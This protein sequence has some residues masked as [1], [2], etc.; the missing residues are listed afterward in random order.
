[1]IVTKRVTRERRGERSKEP[2]TENGEGISKYE[3]GV[4]NSKKRRRR[5]D[6]RFAALPPPQCPSGEGRVFYVGRLCLTRFVSSWCF[7]PCR[8]RLYPRGPGSQVKRARRP[9]LFGRDAEGASFLWAPREL[10]LHALDLRIA[11]RP[12]WWWAEERGPRSVCVRCGCTVSPS[13][14]TPKWASAAGG[15]WGVLWGVNLLRQESGS[16][17]AGS[18]M[19][20][21]YDAAAGAST[22]NHLAV[23]CSSGLSGAS[24]S[25]DWNA[26]SGMPGYTFCS[27]YTGAEMKSTRS[28][29]K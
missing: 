1:M 21:A 23:V 15:G 17:A 2:E 27:K 3:K 4:R 13:P 6:A 14:Q 18:T 28:V 7:S 9:D 20:R 16:R 5:D 25:R 19:I 29:H 11:P 24:C 10:A 12:R 22:R 8:G 26:C